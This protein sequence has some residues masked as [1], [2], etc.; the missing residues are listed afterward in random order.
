MDLLFPA[1]QGIALAGLLIG[2]AWLIWERANH[3]IDETRPTAEPPWR[4]VPPDPRAT[5]IVVVPPAAPDAARPDGD[6]ALPPIP[7]SV[8][9]RDAARHDR[10]VVTELH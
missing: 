8:V 4:L 3:P 2:L 6:D 9:A 1:L 5:L 7:D 10:G